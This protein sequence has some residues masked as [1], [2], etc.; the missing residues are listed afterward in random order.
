MLKKRELHTARERNISYFFTCRSQFMTAHI[1]AFTYRKNNHFFVC[2]ALQ[3]K[4]TDRETVWIGICVRGV[5]VYEVK[6]IINQNVNFCFKPL[7]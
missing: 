2:F 4:K 3:P 7:W 5:T 1:S 6:I